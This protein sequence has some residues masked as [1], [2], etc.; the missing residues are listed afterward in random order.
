MVVF[1]FQQPKNKDMSDE[2]ITREVGVGE[3]GEAPADAEITKLTKPEEDEVGGRY[4]HVSFVEC[5]NCYTVLRIIE[6]TE[7]RKWFQCWNCYIL[8]QY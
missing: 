2:R 3:K 5:P 4:L 8:C 7:S 6:D 1:F